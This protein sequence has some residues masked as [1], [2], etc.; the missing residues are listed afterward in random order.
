MAP[1]QRTDKL[2][3]YVTERKHGYEM[4]VYMG[5]GQPKPTVKLCGPDA[6][7]SEVWRLYEE[8]KNS[9]VVNLSWLLNKY[10]ESD[11]FKSRAADTVKLQ[12]GQIDRISDYKT[13]SGKRF[14]SVEL[15]LISSGVI[16]KYLDARGRDESP[17]AGNREVALISVA[18]NWALERDLVKIPN[19]CGVVKRNKEESRTRYVTDKE[20][21]I[22]YQLAEPTPYLRPAMELAYL[23]RMRRGEI[24]K[25]T[26]AQILDDGFDTLRD[27]GSKDAITL[28]SDRLREAVSYK[29][30]NVGSMY[31]VHTSK[32][33][34]VTLEAFKSAWTRLKKRMV[35]AGIEPFNFHD[36]KAKG[37]SDFEGD[38]QAAGG[39]KD[40]KMVKI[41]DRKKGRVESTK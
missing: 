41:Y 38:K 35:E 25:S 37:V 33:Q 20:Y 26:K 12:S 3:P 4:R 10:R 23:C 16:R 7:L 24:L 36:L 21:E 5:K 19:P 6:P 27:K 31:I 8:H 13:T 11:Q 34:K 28:W 32:G 40:G 18:W 14:G 39:W 15:R 30:G 9:N 17:V 1:K 22:A 29:A 2:P